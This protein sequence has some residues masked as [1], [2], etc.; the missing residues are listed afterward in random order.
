MVKKNILLASAAVVL[1]AAL[2]SVAF[3]QSAAGPFTQAQVDAGRQA[4]ADNCAACHNGDLSG[5][6]DAPQLAGSAFIGAW[7]GRTTE[8]LYDKIS[9]TMPAGRGGSLDET[10]YANIVAYVL[11][12]NGAT[13]GAIA[14]TPATTVG[15][16]SIANGQMPAGLNTASA[17][18]A[19]GQ[20][21]ASARR[22]DSG[23]FSLPTKF[24]LILK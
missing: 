20:S 7:K 4:F 21:A 15:I 3:G 9:K 2:G 6:N 16:G 5:T 8:A 1:G 11:R 17:Q 24:G 18:S 22:I 13:P 23:R 19:G 14:Y 12:A 10:T